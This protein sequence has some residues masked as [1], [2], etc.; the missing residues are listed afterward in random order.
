MPRTARRDP[1]FAADS[2]G[3]AQLGREGHKPGGPAVSDSRGGG[4]LDAAPLVRGS[5]GYVV[6]VRR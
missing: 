3:P 5:F 6:G 4:S 1:A 2:D